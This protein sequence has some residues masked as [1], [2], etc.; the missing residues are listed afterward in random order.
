MTALAP[1]FAYK[2]SMESNKKQKNRQ[3]L[4][5]L[6]W[7]ITI[8]AILFLV[9]CRDRLQPGSHS[10]NQGEMQVISANIEKGEH[11]P[12][13][14]EKGQE[15]VPTQPVTDSK[16][17]ESDD[18]ESQG[19]LKEPQENFPEEQVPVTGEKNETE[20]ASVK[21]EETE[22]EGTE[23]HPNR[24][25]G[26]E[27][28]TELPERS[29]DPERPMVALTFDDG[30][31]RNNTKAIT[32]LFEQY[33]GRAT[34]FVV[35]YHLDLFAEDMMDA[36][37]RGFQIG[38]HTLNHPALRQI[39]DEEAMYEVNELNRRLNELGIP[40]D[41]ML[42]PPYGEYTQYMQEHLSVPMIGWNVDSQDW[43]SKDADKIYEQ[44]VGKVKD[45]DIV[46]LHDLHD[47]TAEAMQRVVP[48]LVAQGFQL[49]TVEELFAAKGIEPQAGHYYCYVR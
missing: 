46:L 48:E 37:R 12:A 42:R 27:E 15:Q 49:V 3:G 4:L 11:I 20:D 14:A 13:N 9:L 26:E 19:E 45:G 10:W 25:P 7:G 18:K 1:V 24:K 2:Y 8:A 34:F 41:V 43:L 6:L 5:W 40:G 23:E 21:G 22:S 32:D 39:S 31:Y 28:T 33:D 30:P 17:A 35:G 29:L 44:I 36:Y 38:N 47:V 16:E